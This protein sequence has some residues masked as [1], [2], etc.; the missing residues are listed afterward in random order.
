MPTDPASYHFTLPSW[1]RASAPLWAPPMVPV[2]WWLGPQVTSSTF[3]PYVSVIAARGECRLSSWLQSS[4]TAWQRHQD[5][6][7][8]LHRAG[9]GRIIRLLLTQVLTGQW[10]RVRRSR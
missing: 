10:M 5:I 7:A 3:H 2:Q 4:D 8:C 1:G 9:V 6:Q